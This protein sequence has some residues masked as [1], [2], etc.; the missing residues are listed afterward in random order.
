MQYKKSFVLASTLVASSALTVASAPAL[1]APVEHVAP[2]AGDDKPGTIGFQVHVQ[3]K[4]KGT[5]RCALYDNESDWLSKKV[6]AD[7]STRVDGEW[8]TCVFSNVQRRGSYG[9]AAFHDEDGDG[10]LDKILGIP[11]EGYSMSR[12]A[13]SKSLVPSWNNAVFPFSGGEVTQTGHMKY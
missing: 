12:D 1:S 5:V 10:E 11:D 9:I 8:V 6:V 2:A 7:A 13:Q 4:R 3:A